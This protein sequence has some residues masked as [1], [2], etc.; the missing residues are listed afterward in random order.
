MHLPDKLL[1]IQ[2]DRKQF[3]SYSLNVK[4]VSQHFLSP[5]KCKEAGT[6]MQGKLAVQSMNSLTRASGQEIVRTTCCPFAGRFVQQYFYLGTQHISYFKSSKSF[7]VTYVAS[8]FYVVVPLS[9]F[10][11]LILYHIWSLE[12]NASKIYQT[13][14]WIHCGIMQLHVFDL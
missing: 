10:A 7:H 4:P 5:N 11:R 3:Y 12:E 8:M 13:I 2:L 14:P 1:S 6:N 9:I